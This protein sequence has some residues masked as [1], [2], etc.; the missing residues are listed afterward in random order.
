MSHARNLELDEV[1]QKTLEEM[2]KHHRKAYMRERAAALLKI[3]SG[4]SVAQV[5][6]DGLLRPRDWGTVANWLNRY[7]QYG[8][9]GLYIR[10]GR[11]RKPAFP[12]SG[13]RVDP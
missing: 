4:Q 5:A 11:G 9:A 8:L 3:A 6:R 10:T 13:V 7:Q 2:R 1:S 12:P